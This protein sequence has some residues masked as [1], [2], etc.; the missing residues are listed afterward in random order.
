MATAKRVICVETG[1]E[2]DSVNRAMIDVN[3]SNIARAIKTGIR[4]AGFHWKYLTEQS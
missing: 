3:S 1:E 2:F 4:A